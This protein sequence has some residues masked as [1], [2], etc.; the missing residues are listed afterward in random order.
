L[1]TRNLNLI[2]HEPELLRALFASAEAY[3]QRSGHRLAEGVRDFFV[4]PDVSAEYVARVQTATAADPWRHGYAV[5]LVAENTIIGACGYKGPPAHKTVEI[6]YGIAPGYRGKG[7]ATEAAMALV[8]RAF[9][10]GLA[11]TVRAHT[12]PERNASARILEKCGFKLL[13]EVND[14]EDGRVWRWEKQKT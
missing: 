3:E 8:D 13:G 12:L 10:T 9:E 2:E 14:P 7:Y 6:G 5:M 1:R 11:N 4:S